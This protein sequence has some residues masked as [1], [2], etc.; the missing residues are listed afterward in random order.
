LLK[1]PELLNQRRYIGIE[2]ND[3]A[4]YLGRLP[5]LLAQTTDCD[6]RCSELWRTGDLSAFLSARAELV[7]LFAEFKFHWKLYERLVRHAEI[8]IFRKAILL[9]QQGQEST[10]DAIAIENKARMRLRELVTV[11][12]ELSND[13]ADLD[14]ARQELWS[15]HEWLAIEIA[16]S[17]SESG[18]AVL[19]H[20]IVGLKRA[21]TAYGYEHTFS[22]AEYAQHW[23]REAIAK[24]RAERSRS[25]DS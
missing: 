11:W 8:P 25:K 17:Q 15:A 14:A 13:L 19:A 1:N 3:R 6:R 5:T 10:S 4:D 23:I 18:P 16:A 22:F 20:A 24:R 9:I 7:A 21:A 2:V 12:E